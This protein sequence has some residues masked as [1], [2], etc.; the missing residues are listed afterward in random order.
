MT[1]R[2]GNEGMEKKM[3][4]MGIIGFMLGFYRDYEVYIGAKKRK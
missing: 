3:E 1:M 2:R 4:A